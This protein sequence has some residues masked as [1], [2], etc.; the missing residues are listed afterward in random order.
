MRP[1][2]SGLIP[3]EFIAA[4]EIPLACTVVSIMPHPA[5]VNRAKTTASHLDFRPFS[6]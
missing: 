3:R 2:T 1:V 6:M 5:I 4:V